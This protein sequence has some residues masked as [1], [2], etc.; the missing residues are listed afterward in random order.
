MGKQREMQWKLGY[1]GVLRRK[2][3]NAGVLYLK[4]R[5]SLGTWDVWASL[6]RLRIVRV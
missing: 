2:Y 4:P 6:L 1:I 5:V 3:K